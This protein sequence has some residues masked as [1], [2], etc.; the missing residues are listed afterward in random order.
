VN[1]RPV[2]AAAS[3]APEL[4]SELRR[5][6]LENAQLRS[7]LEQ[8]AVDEMDAPRPF[9]PRW[10]WW[11]GRMIAMGLFATGVALATLMVAESSPVRQIRGAVR[12]ALRDGRSV[13]IH[14]TR[15]VLPPIPPIPAIPPIPPLP[16]SH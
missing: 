9:P 10:R 7:M 8:L 11:V 14:E 5:L 6:E 13:R 4:L 2:I 15:V 16:H 1:E 12:T 3:P